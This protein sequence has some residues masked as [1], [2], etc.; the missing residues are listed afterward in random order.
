MKNHFIEPVVTLGVNCHRYVPG[1]QFGLLRS[2][3]LF[4]LYIVGQ[5]GTGKTTL[6]KNMAT[7]DV[8]IGQGFCFLDPHGD[9]AEALA[10]CLG[11]NGIYW[12]LPNPRCPYGYNPLS[13]V[14]QEYRPLV[15]SGVIDTLK[16]QWSDAWG[17]RMEHLLRFALLA[18]LDRPGST[19]L[20][21]IPMFT[22]KSFRRQV[23]QH[24]KDEEVLKFW[25]DEFPAMNYRNSF[26]GVAPIANKLG[27][28]LANPVVRKALCNPE[29]PL[30]FR[31]LMDNG[32]PLIVNLAKGRLGTDVSNIMGGL[33]FSCMAH[34]AYSRQNIME[35]RRKPYFLYADE[36]HSFTTEAIADM[37]PELRKYALGLVLANQF[38]SQLDKT[39]FAAIT[40][41]VG[42]TLVFRLGPDDAVKLSKLFAPKISPF[43]IMNLPNYR[44]YVRMMVR[45]EITKVLS[46]VTQDEM[47]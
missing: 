38:T 16:K 41:N 24:V 39:V 14:A 13:Y 31:T 9:V 45:G 19:L 6:L 28:F 22:T 12:D 43:D 18:L 32:T 40:G 4:H 15:A 3:R 36:F 29:Q 27:A 23:L 21:I 44:F 33:I 35:K 46:G 10:G 8:A 30:R 42:T 26:D 17:V 1:E 5:T 34:A 37:L 47:P 11:G 2:D 7:Q 25:K 20:D